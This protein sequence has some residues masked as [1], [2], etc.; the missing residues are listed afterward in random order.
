MKLSQ[1]L[2]DLASDYMEIG[3]TLEEKQN[4]LNVVCIAWNISLLPEN[5]RDEALAH[6][7]MAYKENNPLDEDANIRNIKQDMEL[8]ISKKIS[9][10]P[11]AAT[12]IE[13]AR[14]TEDDDEYK[15]LVATSPGSPASFS[16]TKH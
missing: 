12:P 7:L 4:H 10:F 14:I 1:M 16:M 9:Q 6:F 5:A 3:T 8:L 13:Y 2:I 15:I 11:N